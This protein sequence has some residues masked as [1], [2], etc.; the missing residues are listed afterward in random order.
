MTQI[1]LKAPVFR[2]LVGGTGRRQR[3]RGLSDRAL[4]FYFVLPSLLLL[5]AINIF[6]L[7]WN[8]YLSFTTYRANMPGFPVRWVGDLNY[9]RLLGSEDVWEYMQHTAHFVGWT[10]LIQ[11]ILGFGAGLA[12]EPEI[13]GGR[14]VCITS[15]RVADDAVARRWWAPSGPICSSRRRASSTT[16]ST[17]SPMSATSP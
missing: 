10:M 9:Q 17:F 12:V 8:I 14:A 2:R 6:P 5:L 15:D 11:V 4:A 1:P 13:P 16:S 3:V 7:A